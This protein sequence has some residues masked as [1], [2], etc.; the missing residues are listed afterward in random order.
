MSRLVPMEVHKEAKCITLSFDRIYFALIWL[1]V[2]AKAVAAS[3]SGME[4][5]T[6]IIM[7]VIMGLMSGRLAGICFKVHRLKI[8]HNFSV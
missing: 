7:C 5:W 3:L 2:I 6:D 4:V 1:L 8:M